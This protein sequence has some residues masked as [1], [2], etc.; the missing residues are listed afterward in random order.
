LL[1]ADAFYNKFSREIISISNL[2]QVF[3]GLD[4]SFRF[5]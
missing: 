1:V 5:V 3:I 2:L 4:K